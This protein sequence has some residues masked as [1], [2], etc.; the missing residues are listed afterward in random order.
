[1]I[2]SAIAPQVTGETTVLDHSRRIRVI[3]SG[4]S[5]SFVAL[6]DGLQMSLHNY[7]VHTTHINRDYV[8]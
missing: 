2:K 1:M 4:H 7:K 8:L 5:W 6:S 3:G